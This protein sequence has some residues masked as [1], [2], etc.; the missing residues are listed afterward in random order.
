MVDLKCSENNAARG[1]YTARGVRAARACVQ[2]VACWVLALVAACT[3]AF[4][5]VAPASV[6][7]TAFAEEASADAAQVAGTAH[8]GVVGVDDPGAESPK[9]QTWVAPAEQ[10]FA[11]G[12][13]AWD[14]LKASLDEAGLAYDAQDSSYGIFIQSITSPEGVLVENT[15]SEPYSYWAFLVNGEMASVGVSSYELQ[16]GDTVELVYYPGGEAPEIEPVA[17]EDDATGAED[18]SD[19]ATAAAS[20]S[21]PEASGPNMALVAGGV[22]AVVVVALIVAYVVKARKN[23]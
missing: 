19:V 18:A 3:L 23:K 2:R 1:V 11:A 17:S 22:I 13:T 8:V 5:P 10:D 16:D 21:T 12:A 14:V 6:V 7:P 15:S 9:G 20:E 4:S